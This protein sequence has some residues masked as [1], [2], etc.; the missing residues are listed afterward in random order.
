MIA[1]DQNLVIDVDGGVV[2]DESVQPDLEF[3]LE[4]FLDNRD[5]KLLY[6]AEVTVDL[7]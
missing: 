7:Q 6:V 2:H 5:R 4:N 3:M 1:L